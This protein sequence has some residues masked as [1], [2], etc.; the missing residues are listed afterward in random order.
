[1]NLGFNIQLVN[2]NNKPVKLTFPVHHVVTGGI[3]CLVL[4]EFGGFFHV[5]LFN[6]GIVD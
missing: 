1:M 2:K 6:P 5:F 4:T 3:L